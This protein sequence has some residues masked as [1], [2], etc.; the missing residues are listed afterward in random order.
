MPI[1][2]VCAVLILVISGTAAARAVTP[3][4]LAEIRTAVAVTGSASVIVVFKTG[5]SLENP[6]DVP[7]TAPPRE[8]AQAMLRTQRQR[9]ASAVTSLN[10]QFPSFRQSVF[11]PPLLAS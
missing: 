7:A 4:A 5:I 10:C 6:A 2:L 11:R 3:E 8:R 1:R 9:V